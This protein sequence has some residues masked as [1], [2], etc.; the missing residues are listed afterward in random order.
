M[1]PGAASGAASGAALG[2]APPASG[3]NA[4]ASACRR[5]AA[6]RAGP[7]TSACGECLE[8]V[9]VALDRL[10][11][12]GRRG[13]AEAV[14]PRDE[15]VD[16]DGLGERG[17]V[18]RRRPADGVGERAREQ[19]PKPSA[20]GR[21]APRSRRAAVARGHLVRAAERQA[22][23]AHQRVGELGDRDAGGVRIGAHA[24]N[25]RSTPRRRRRARGSARARPR[26]LRGP[27]LARA[28]RPA[29]RAPPVRS[30]G[31]VASS[32]ARCQP[33]RS[34]CRRGR[35]NARRVLRRQRR[36]GPGA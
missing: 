8:L 21:R 7:S 5:R 4:A 22:L 32:A 19:R 26:R 18:Q 3:A 30:R 31:S 15:R 2:A 36:P 9:V 33:S 20:S 10:V 25:R 12:R 11:E 17:S 6:M 13:P 23:L 29:L 16:R 34:L 24:R 27:G 35:P 14:A 1:A 28:R